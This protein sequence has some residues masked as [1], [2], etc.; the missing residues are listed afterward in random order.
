VINAGAGGDT[1]ESGRA[2]CEA[3]VLATDPD[4]VIIQLGINDAAVDV[5][6]DPPATASRVP[7]DRYREN[8]ESFVDTLQARGAR[9][10]LMTPNR[11]RWSDQ[12]RALYGKPPYD[13]AD[14]DGFAVTMPPY[15]EAVRQVAAAKG[16]TLIDVWAAYQ[17]YDAVEGQSMDE[18]LLD[19]MHPNAA[20]HRLVADRLL[21]A[22]HSPD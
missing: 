6:R 22:V 7:L 13:P 4:L 5:W 14:P 8:L 19:G 17:E 3:D 9:V 1:T 12:T 15:V 20:G 16:V 10:I 2:R 21:A 11:I 18:L